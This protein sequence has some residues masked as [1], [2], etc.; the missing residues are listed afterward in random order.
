MPRPSRD[1][2]ATQTG[3]CLRSGH[4]CRASV[5]V[6]SQ[7]H[8]RFPASRLGARPPRGRLGLPLLTSTTTGARL[9]CPPPP[10]SPPQLSP[11]RGLASSVTLPT[12]CTGRPRR[13][14]ARSRLSS[15]HSAACLSSSSRLPSPL[16]LGLG[17]YY[18]PF[19]SF[20]NNDNR[21]SRRLH[22]VIKQECDGSGRV[23][24]TVFS[25]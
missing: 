16:A 17:R 11:T 22:K 18:T 10:R 6:A 19:T 7:Q 15:W 5:A 4:S 21:R 13:R 3:K 14:G 2:P 1:R 8:R 12:R 9:G 24:R 23:G 20:T 25:A